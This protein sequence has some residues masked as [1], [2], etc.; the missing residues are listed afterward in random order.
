MG[1]SMKKK[2]DIDVGGVIAFFLFIA[3]IIAGLIYIVTSWQPDQIVSEVYLG[4]IQ[5]IRAVNPIVYGG[6]N[7]DYD[8]AIMMM[9]L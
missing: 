1:E 8:D 2:D 4:T 3:A 7:D 6:T 5:G 9:R